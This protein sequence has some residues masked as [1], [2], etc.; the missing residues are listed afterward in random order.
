M[1]WK[2]KARYLL[3]WSSIPPLFFV[4]RQMYRFAISIS[5]L[6]FRQCRGIRSVYLTRGCTKSQIAPGVSDIDFILVVGPDDRERRRA[7]SVFRSLD[8]FSA[9]LIPYHSSFVVNEEELHYRWHTTPVWRYRYQEG[10]FNWSLLHGTEMLTALPPITGSERTSSCFSEMHYWWT[11]FVDF[12]LQNEMY[13]GDIVLRRA[14]CIKAVPEV[15]N[16]LNALRTGEFCF[17]REEALRRE[18]SPLCRKLRENATQRVPRRDKAVEEACFR[19]LVQ[20]FLDLWIEFRDDPFL[21]VYRDV[22]QTVQ[23]A[24]AALEREKAQAPFREISRYLA[25][26]WNGR[27]QGVHLVKSAFYQLEDSLLLI[28]TSMDSLPSLGDLERLLALRRRVYAGC[29]TPTWFFLRLG[30]VIFPI[31]PNVPR[32]YN[33]GVLTPATAPDVF[34][35][36]DETPVYWTSHTNWYLTDWRRN[37]QWLDAPP[38][39]QAQLEMI[40]RSASAGHVV[41]PLD[42]QDVSV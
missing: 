8:V 25:D 18:D 23:P 22:Q 42:T 26:E 10:K 36:L 5:V 34:L 2:T 11:Q 41:Y 40:S 30:Q 12:L 14:I 15:L 3:A 33:R 1:A 16:A 32:D 19:F 31:T 4:Y 7:E 28:D 27:C 39:K 35:Q 6:L 24:T 38:L 37:R 20:S 29:Q 17:S 21:P 9:G 13:R